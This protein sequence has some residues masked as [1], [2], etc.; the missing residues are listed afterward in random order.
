MALNAHTLVQD[1]TQLNRG[2]EIEARQHDVVHYR[3]MVIDTA[4]GLGVVWISEDLLGS[5]KLLHL[6]EYSIWRREG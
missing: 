3:G 1:L 4:P 6:D 2:D 5:R